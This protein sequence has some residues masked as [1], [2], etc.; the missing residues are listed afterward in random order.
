M[1]ACSHSSIHFSRFSRI[2]APP[3]GENAYITPGTFKV[4]DAGH[5]SAHKSDMLKQSV[6]HFSA[7]P[8]GRRPLVR[9]MNGSVSAQ[10][11]TSG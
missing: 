4:S 3:R 5:R 9:L 6:T 10:E 2:W 8:S 7:A 11:A 1:A